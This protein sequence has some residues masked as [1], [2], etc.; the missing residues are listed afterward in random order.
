MSDITPRDLF[1]AINKNDIKK[2]KLL[3][4]NGANPNWSSNWREYEPFGGSSDEYE[5]ALHLAMQIGNPEI[6]KLLLDKGAE[7][8][9]RHSTLT[10]YS[11]TF[12]VSDIISMFE[13]EIEKLKKENKE[14][15]KIKGYLETIS[16]L[17]T[18][19]K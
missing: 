14:T 16:K 1:E 15:E 12:G 8:T 19:Y 10:Q 3:L 7:P 11:P 18:A 13:A 6:V 17:K 2:V 9:Y 4:D 5:T